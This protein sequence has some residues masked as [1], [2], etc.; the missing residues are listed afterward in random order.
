MQSNERIV[1]RSSAALQCA[2]PKPDADLERLGA[3]YAPATEYLLADCLGCRAYQDIPWCGLGELLQ[4]HLD[5]LSVPRRLLVRARSTR[6]HHSARRPFRRVCSH[7]RSDVVLSTKSAVYQLAEFYIK[8]ESRRLALHWAACGR[9]DLETIPRAVG[10]AS[11][12]SEFYGRSVLGIMYR[13]HCER[14]TPKAGDTDQGR[15]AYSVSLLWLRRLS[16]KV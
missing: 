16:D 13:G 4:V 6:I 12:H 11:P 7:P 3:T 2:T 1:S 14:A 9:C 15:V 5:L 8:P 10:V